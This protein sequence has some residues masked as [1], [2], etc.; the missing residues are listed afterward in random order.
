MHKDNGLRTQGMRHNEEHCV[1]VF[2]MTSVNNSFCSM[3][4]SD[5]EW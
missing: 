2:Q 5:H 1:R 3:R 4:S